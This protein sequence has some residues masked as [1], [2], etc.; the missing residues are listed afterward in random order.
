MRESFHD[1]AI[2][3]ARRPLNRRR[4]KHRVTS[5]DE[6]MMNDWY[7]RARQIERLAY[8]GCRA[9]HRLDEINVPDASTPRSRNRA[10]KNE[11]GGSMLRPAR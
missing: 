8:V 11:T 4:Y 1:F 7:R 10:R 9:S 6:V 5:G 3:T 2:I